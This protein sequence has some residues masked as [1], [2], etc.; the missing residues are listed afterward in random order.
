[1]LIGSLNIFKYYVLIIMYQT[2]FKGFTG[3]NSINI[4]A[5]AIWMLNYKKKKKKSWFKN[6]FLLK[7]SHEI[8]GETIGNSVVFR[9][10]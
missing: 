6:I 7:C 8:Y 4:E 2:W 10:T 5:I 3:I 9:K 1:M